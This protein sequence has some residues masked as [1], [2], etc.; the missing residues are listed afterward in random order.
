[1]SAETPI[2][3]T[4]GVQ[5]GEERFDPDHC[6]ICE[7]DR[8]YVGWNGQQWTTLA[9]FAA[10]GHRNELREEAGVWGVGT[11]PSIAI[12]QRAC[13]VPGE[14]G[15]VLWDCITY[16]DDET[17]REVERL[18]G[19]AAIA[20]SHPHFYDSMIEWSEAFGGIPVYI[21]EADREWVCRDGNVVFWSGDTREILPGRTLVNC[22][23]H[24][25]GGTVLHW[26]DGAD[27]RGALFSGDIFAVVMDRR[28]VSFMYSFPN[29][30]PE[31]PDTIARAV[32]LVGQFDFE[33]IYGAW[34][35]R[36]VSAD[37]KAAVVRSAERYFRHIGLE[38]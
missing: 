25:P 14:G 38:R 11:S 3:R 28:W 34:W 19:L 26:A 1:M 24:F 12:G 35:G 9:E 36:V 30:I 15:N 29:I 2:C 17:V 18:G 13:V 37:A 4:C 33:M 23:T 22:G 16:I 20:I 10:A 27:G 6:K 5:Y 31:H 7:D 21:H 32:E 8:Q